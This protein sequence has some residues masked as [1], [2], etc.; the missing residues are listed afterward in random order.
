LFNFG[1]AD[2]YLILRRRPTTELHLSRSPDRDPHRTAGSIYLRVT[3]TQ[4]VY[5]SVR[6]ALAREG[7]LYLSLDGEDRSWAAQRSR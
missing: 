7:A 6:A 3:D 5:D 4:P 1:R 2:D